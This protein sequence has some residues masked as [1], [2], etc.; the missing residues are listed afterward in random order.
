MY[1]MAHSFHFWVTPAVARSHSLFA[2]VLVVCWVLTT[3]CTRYDAARGRGKP[4]GTP[5]TV[6]RCTSS[7][8]KG[9]VVMKVE[10]K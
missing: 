8:L 10:R 4:D 6:H 5:G 9:Y 7:L 1:L 2:R 3:M